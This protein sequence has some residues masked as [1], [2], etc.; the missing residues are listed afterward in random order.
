M[1]KKA[2][3]IGLLFFFALSLA[4]TSF[5]I[6]DDSAT[7]RVPNI[8]F[9]VSYDRYSIVEQKLM[10]ME[11]ETWIYI[12]QAFRGTPTLR[13]I[14]KQKAPFQKTAA[15]YLAPGD[16]VATAQ[17]TG[18]GEDTTHYRAYSWKPIVFSVLSSTAAS[19]LPRIVV[20]V[21]VR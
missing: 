21:R 2:V 3:S 6:S 9:V 15:M 20:P 18:P 8:S 7:I 14:A 10:D 5:A 11:M 12:W 17:N 16:Y 13:L 19:P 4:G 1:I